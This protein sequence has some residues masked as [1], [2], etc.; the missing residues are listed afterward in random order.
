MYDH[1]LMAGMVGALLVILLIG[2]VMRRFNQ[3]HVVGYLIAGFILG[4]DILGV[5]TNH[6]TLSRMGDFGV[7]LLLFFIGLEVSLPRLISRWKLVVFATIAQILISI[8]LMTLVGHF[9]GWPAG[10]SVLLGFIISLSSTAVVIKILEDWKQI[11]TPMGQKIL[12]ILLLQ[13]IALIPMILILNFFD[14][15]SFDFS[16]MLL[17]TAGSLIIVGILMWVIIRGKFNLPYAEKIRQDHELQIFVAL[18]L[19]FGLAF[20][21]TIFGLSSA[22]GAFV[23]GVVISFS[24]ETSWIQ[25]RLEPFKVVFVALFFVSIGMLINLPFIWNNLIEIITIVLIVFFVNSLVMAVLFRLFR[26]DWHSALYAGA[27]LSQIGE[28]GFVLALTG[29]TMHFVS[30]YTYQLTLSIIAFTLLLSPMWINIV[31]RSRDVHL[32]KAYKVKLTQ[33]RTRTVNK[34]ADHDVE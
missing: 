18:V 13:D 22:L 27:L 28:F 4:P 7:M 1:E 24:Q 2:L 3:P 25:H 15:M 33:T 12:G 34:S 21:T 14:S 5:I 6:A 8:G 23:A 9:A 29:K 31:K 17:Q 26:H 11:N 16:K 19:C 30:D 10:R 32:L 20:I